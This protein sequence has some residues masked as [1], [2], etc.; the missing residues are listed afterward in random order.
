MQPTISPV[1]A[2]GK[3]RYTHSA[4]LPFRIRRIDHY[5]GKEMVQNLLVL[6]FGNLF[7]GPLWNRDHIAAVIIS[8]KE[9]FGTEGRG[10]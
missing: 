9:D 7:L 2:V 4:P 1:Q 6:R 8:F 5:L 3:P 10:G